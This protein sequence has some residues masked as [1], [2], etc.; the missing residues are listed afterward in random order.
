MKLITLFLLSLACFAQVQINAPAVTLDATGVA[1][2]TAW[3]ATQGTGTITTIT[4]PVAIG[5]TTVNVDVAQ[6]IPVNA[7]IAI[8]VEHMQVT[9]KAGRVLTVTRAQNGTVAA[10][11]ATGAQV[12]ELKYRTLNA[13]GKA[14]IVGIAKDLVDKYAPLN[15]A[16]AAAQAAKDAAREAAVQ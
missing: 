16:I 2:V 9:A 7:V 10:A 13:F 15:A 5:A 1:A 12:T 8:G 6:S 4:A 11:Y 14:V 3:M